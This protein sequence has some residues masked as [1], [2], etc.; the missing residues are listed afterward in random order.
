LTLK[1]LA[2]PYDLKPK[3]H[4]KLSVFIL[5][6]TFLSALGLSIVL[7][8]SWKIYKQL[9]NSRA[10]DRSRTTSSNT[11]H[12]EITTLS[13]PKL[14]A[15]DSVM[16]ARIFGLMEN[17][18]KLSFPNDNHI[19]EFE[20]GDLE[21][22]GLLAANARHRIGK[23]RHIPSNTVFAAKF[24]TIPYDRFDN[25]DIRKHYKKM[26]NE[27]ENFRKLWEC[28]NIVSFYGLCIYEGHVLLCMELMDLS[29]K[30]LYTLVHSTRKEKFSEETI[31]Y[32]FVKIFDALLYCS[33]K[34]VLH[35]DIKPDNILVN[36]RQVL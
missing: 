25:E 6:G 8:L 4:G 1:P 29:L 32:I 35:R 14:P 22:L 9:K 33:S 28:E 31:G 5:V 17:V 3:Q 19:H 13:I 18:N 20:W 30:Q 23:F 12:T 15:P 11:T 34:K 24:L 36:R 16:F 26:L 10:P 27:I 2:L 7:F 21:N